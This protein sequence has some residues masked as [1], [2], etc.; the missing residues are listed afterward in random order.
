[1][2]FDSKEV[3]HYKV[4]TMTIDP[5]VLSD[6]LAELALRQLPCGGWGALASSSQPAIE[7]TCYSALALGS[8]PAGD[9]E[10]AQDFLLHTQN[11]N[12]SWPV[13]P[14]DDQ[15]GGWVTSLAVMVL[16]EAIPAIPARLQGF[17]WL[18]NCAGKE[19][20]WF[21]K[22][23]FRTAD[24]HVRFDP[25]KFGWPWFPDTV[26]W[27]VP[28]AF[29]VLVLSQLP[30][31]CGGLEPVPFRVER[32]VEM[33]LDRACPGGG[34][35]AGNGVV[36]G[37]ALAPHADDTAIALLALRD[38]AKE[39]VVQGSVDYLERVA[40]TLTAPWS[41]A[42]A[43]LALTAHRR[44]TSSLSSSLVALPDLSSIEDT[45]TLAVVCLALDQPRALQAFGVTL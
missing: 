4:R 15:E 2:R 22:W 10:R 19:S 38:R 32:G 43:I 1:M 40:A 26:S 39:P 34:W 37:S 7:P 9:I 28:T 20:N 41:L 25:D 13:F 35:N 42:W 23:K 16:R 24:R 30:C 18:M 12:G 11:P 5:I 44:P 14:G 31:S 8:V 27:V 21:W 33:L 29:A 36:Y 17:H 6:L 3:S 45:S